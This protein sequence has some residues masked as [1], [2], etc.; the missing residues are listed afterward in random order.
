MH[1]LNI[2]R[3]A[4][5]VISPPVKTGYESPVG[6]WEVTGVFG[7][8]ANS[9]EVIGTYHGHVAEIA[10]HLA[11]RTGWELI[12]KPV[13]HMVKSL[14]PKRE[15]AWAASKTVV[16]IRLDTYP[17]PSNASDYLKEL[18]FKNWLDCDDQV[19]VKACHAGQRL[20]QAVCLLLK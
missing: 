4:P 15:K 13:F 19:E 6:W 16:W 7:D 8:E 20:W 11:D 2:A 10:F 9:R 14:P 5:K 17:I 12:F 3:P 1:K 18:W